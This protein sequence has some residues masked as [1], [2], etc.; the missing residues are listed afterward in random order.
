MSGKNQRIVAMNWLSSR[1]NRL[2]FKTLGN[3]SII[4]EESTEYT[5]IDQSKTGRC[6]HVT[7]WI[8]NH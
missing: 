3:L 8:L 2:K 1:N 6:R 5:S 7:G 4:L